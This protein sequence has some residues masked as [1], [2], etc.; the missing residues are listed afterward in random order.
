MLISNTSKSQAQA[1]LLI[2]AQLRASKAVSYSKAFQLQL[3]QVRQGD[4]P[5]FP[6]CFLQGRAAFAVFQAL[7]YG[8]YFI[9][10][11]VITLKNNQ[12]SLSM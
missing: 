4:Y 1:I 11:T 5:T 10:N 6:G 2:A 9:K 3:A 12:F 8:R 7:S